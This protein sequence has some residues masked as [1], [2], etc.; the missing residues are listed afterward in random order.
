MHRRS[1]THPHRFRQAIA[2]VNP[3]RR[4]AHKQAVA[5]G[6]PVRNHFGDEHLEP[7]PRIRLIVVEPHRGGVAVVTQ[8]DVGSGFNVQARLVPVD[9]IMRNGAGGRL[10]EAGRVPHLECFLIRIPPG[11]V[12]EGL[13]HGPAAVKQPLL[14]MRFRGLFAAHFVPVALL[15]GFPGAV[16]PDH[17]AGVVVL[18]QMIR[19]PYILRALH[20]KI[21]HKKLPPDV[22]GDDFRHRGRRK[23]GHVHRRIGG[24]A[25]RW[26]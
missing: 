19:A 6:C 3:I 2:P 5:I 26:P 12:T 20:Q 10:V 17:G 22:D 23:I 16:R 24:L 8:D 4:C 13:R 25:S 11:P 1:I 18:C 21:V 15:E 9:G 7:V 14:A